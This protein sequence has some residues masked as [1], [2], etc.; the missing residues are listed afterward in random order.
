ME[1]IGRIHSI[2][3]FGSVDGP[4]IRFI[5]FLHG[6]PFRCV[7]CHNPDTWASET[8]EEMSAKQAYEKAMRYKTYWKKNGGITVSGGEP[9]L[10]LDFIIE[11][12]TMIKQAGYTTC[13]DT[14]GA[15]FSRR[16]PFF[17]KFEKLM[18]VCDLLLV[19]MKEFNDERHKKITGK[20]NANVLDMLQYLSDIRK[21]IWIRHVLVPGY[22]DFDE[23]L[24]ALGKYL[25]TLENVARVEVLPYHTLGIFKW[26]QLG[27]PYVLD[28]VK[29][30]SKER[31][32]NA[33]RLLDVGSYTQF[34]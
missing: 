33:E 26:E 32:I 21:P 22:S 27:I 5:F 10:Q 11:L 9:L 8:Y 24:T 28:G 20:P 6:C 13:I 16:D 7:Y 12:F 29:P 14:S 18:D 31:K 25:K 30:P 4:G 23:D 19:D 15:C 34:R 17:S 2:E 3:T 1:T